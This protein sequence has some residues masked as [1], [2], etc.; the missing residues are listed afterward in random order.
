M[1]HDETASK[2]SRD[3]SLITIFMCGDVM[4]GRGIDQILPHPSDPLIHERY[5][6]TLKFR[7][8]PPSLLSL[9]PDSFVYKR[10]VKDAGEYV[11]LAEQANGPVQK[12][13]DFS[14]IWGDALEELERMSPDLRII[15]LE[16]SITK[17]DDYWKGKGIN[18]RMHPENIPCITAAKIDCCSLANNHVLDWGHSGLLQTLEI[19]DRVNMKRAGAGRNARES[20]S[21]AVMEVG[22]KGRVILFS[23]GLKTS[24]I[25]PSWA[26]S[27]ERSGVNLLEELS[28]KTVLYIQGIIQRVKQQGD[29][30]IISLHW[31]GNWGY[32]IPHKQREFAHKLIDEA[33]VDIIHGHSSHHIKGIEVY[34]ERPIMYGCGDLIN[35]YEGISRLY[36]HF[37]KDLGLMYFVSSDPSTGK[38][39]HLRMIPTQVKHLKVNRASREDALWLKNTLDRECKKLETRVELN[40]DNTLTLKWI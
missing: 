32:T 35:D 6:R 30:V 39:V 10:Y 22:G 11:K 14:Y 5:M 2:S 23:F 18:Y 38:L 24:G 12:P 27:E 13:V 3:P 19:L 25:P 9:L 26:A 31:G 33:G 40:M 20:A 4:T 17:S 16:T 29:I 21:P 15:N 28:H 7:R 1:A 34:K 8:V 36:D 37:R